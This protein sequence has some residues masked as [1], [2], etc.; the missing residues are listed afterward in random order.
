VGSGLSGST[1]ARTL[2][3]NGWFVEVNEAA[4]FVGGHVRTAEYQGLLYEQNAIHVNHTNSDQ[5]INFIKRFAEWIPYV[6][7][8]K[9]EIPP[10]TISWPPQIDELRKLKEW[11]QIEKELAGLPKTAQ[12]Q[13]F[14]T[15]AVSIMGATLY[16][17]LILPYTIKQWGTE[18]KNL[19]SEFAPKRID[20][21]SDGFLPMFRDKW[22][23]W[24]RGGWTKLIENI[25]NHE[26]VKVRLGIALTEST[27]SW[28]DYDCVVVT[29]ALDDFLG[30]RQ[31][32]WRG[33][34]V[35]HEYI[36]NHR[37]FFLPAGQV[38]HPGLDKSYTRRTE[39]KHMSGQKALLGTIVTYE[40]PGSKEKH[41]PVH[42][43]KGGNRAE[44]SRLKKKLYSLHPNAVTA[45]RLANYVYINTDQAITQ[46]LN[47]A[48]KAFYIE[49]RVKKL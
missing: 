10:G 46:G 16:E 44:A 12:T 45:G 28:E 6:H 32:P 27:I 15:Y 13:N 49:K 42:D 33:V 5:V 29:C 34:R 43:F 31:L 41:Y 37:G 21:R 4:Y 38:N 24:P 19:S 25:L 20:L 26:R 35:E 11:A 39:T 3:D 22:Q 1:A 8:A 40:Y 18:P 30:E 14:E 47:A 36:P 7:Y 23:G 2:A 9:T 17:W 48:Q